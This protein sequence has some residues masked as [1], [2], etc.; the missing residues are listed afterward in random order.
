MR[1]LLIHG[2]ISSLA[3]YCAKPEGH[4]FATPYE[5][6][7]VYYGRDRGEPDQGPKT[8]QAEDAL[9]AVQASWAEF[10]YLFRDGCWHFSR[11]G[12]NSKLRPLTLADT[13]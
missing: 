11:V 3:E 13:L 7:T 1:E 4:S 5:G 9:I 12:P 2:N 10:F 8:L 6:Y